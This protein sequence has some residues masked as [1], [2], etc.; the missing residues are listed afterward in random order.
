MN[1]NDYTVDKDLEPTDNSFF[2]MDIEEVANLLETRPEQ[3]NTTHMP[4]SVP[5]TLSSPL[6][7]PS[8]SS[9]RQSE[10]KAAAG[11]KRLRQTVEA[12]V[13]TRV[14]LQQYATS[15]TRQFNRWSETEKIFL[16]GVVLDVYFR[17]HS[18]KPSN[19]ERRKAVQCGISVKTLVWHEVQRKYLLACMRYGMLTGEEL[20]SRSARALQK[21][22]KDTGKEGKHMSLKARVDEDYEPKTKTRARIWDTVYNRENVLIGSEIN[23]ERKRRNPCLGYPSRKMRR[24]FSR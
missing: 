2:F 6:P 24:R 22:W 1:P 21:H 17:R 15:P 5:L 12:P 19:E 3:S 23:F 14:P 8:P 13:E 16:T 18:L 4:L 9:S 11:T 10:V 20:P 7:V